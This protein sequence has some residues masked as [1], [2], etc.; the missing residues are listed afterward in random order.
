MQQATFGSRRICHASATPSTVAMYE[1]STALSP[2]LPTCGLA[3]CRLPPLPLQTPVARPKI[4]IAFDDAFKSQ[5][6]EAFRYMS[7]FGLVGTIAVN[8]SL[9][10]TANYCS[11]A[12]L[13][14]MYAAGWHICGHTP[15]HTAIIRP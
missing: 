14:A 3:L 15:S 9:I 11:W 6:T 2:K 10:G 7:R 1:P 8:P 5:Y 12:Q 4:V 13:Q